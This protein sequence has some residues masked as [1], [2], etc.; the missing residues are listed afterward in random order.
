MQTEE[1]R[2][3]TE[4]EEMEK[5]DLVSWLQDYL[6]CLKK[7]WLQFLLLF[8]IVAGI[9]V[10][11]FE[12]T[13]E[14][15]Y[16]AKITYAASGTEY[17][18]VNSAVAKRLSKSI[19]VLTANDEFKKDLLSA[20][21]GEVSGGFSIVS[22]NTD[23]SNFFSVTISTN[24]YESVNPLLEAF[25]KVYPKWVSKTTG[26]VELQIVDKT[27]SS[28]RPVNV[29][30]LAAIFA[31]GFLAG[32]VVCFAL[33]TVYLLS[34]R[35]VRKESDMKRITS[36][37]CIN[38]IPE[39]VPKKR[40]N[41]KKLKLLITNKRIDWGFK[42]SILMIQSRLQQIMRRTGNK[43]LLITSTIPAEGK[44]MTSVNM[45]LAF[46]QEGMKVALLDGDL[47]K[48]S[49]SELMK[50]PEGP[51]L[52]EYFRGESTPEEI[53]V[54]KDGVTFFRAGQK[55]GKVSGLIDE[56]KM[57]SLLEKLRKEYDVILMDAAPSYVFSDAMIL[58]SYADK[59]LYVVRVDKA[60]AKEIRVGMNSFEEKEKL[61]G[62]VIN[63]DTGGYISQSGY[64]YGRYGKYQKYRKYAELDEET[65][66]T[67]DTL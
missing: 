3:I 8:V 43:V 51:G 42:Q 11:Y 12:F 26:T 20:V 62:Y 34:V 64:G 47:R 57:N 31:K 1:Q 24:D 40:S 67:E 15:V 13:Y 48:P 2:N 54:V 58:S 46:A 59:V 49:V 18:T 41:N 66:N 16:S 6:S 56:E 7:F 22:S 63:R 17:M 44:T 23:E 9:I 53:Q 52:T 35:T 55:K 21:D 5:I 27:A 19:P 32:L 10:S 60:D 29:N 38:C 25:Q 61:I 14:P 37:R 28:G 4:A 50:L 65:M 33:A 45:A 39:V 36:A 30:S